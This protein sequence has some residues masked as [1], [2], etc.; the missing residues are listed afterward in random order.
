MA[1]RLYVGN[2]PYDITEEGLRELFSPFGQVNTATIIIN[3][4]N[5]RSKGFGFV[6]F[7]EDASAREAIEKLNDSQ[8]GDRKIVV[9][10][11]KPREERPSNG[12]GF[13]NNR[14][15]GFRDHRPQ[16]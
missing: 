10:E 15:G 8:V 11:A 14:S 6:E 13:S 4:F 5:N 3:K 9:N 7:A 12:G 2:L 1:I 16:R